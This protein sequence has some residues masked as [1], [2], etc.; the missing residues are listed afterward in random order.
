MLRAWPQPI[1]EIG[2][3]GQTNGMMAVNIHFI[4]ERE[5]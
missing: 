4:N 5:Q 2:A 3:R 1:T